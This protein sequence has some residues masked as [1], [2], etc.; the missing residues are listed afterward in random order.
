MSL[1]K[2]TRRG[3]L[4]ILASTVVLVV[5]VI[6]SWT[7]ARGQDGNVVMETNSETHGV[8][9]GTIVLI[10]G[11]CQPGVVG[12]TSRTKCMSRSVSRKVYLYSP[13]VL[14]RQFTDTYYG[15]YRSPTL[16]G[17]SDGDGHYEIQIRPGPYSILVEDEMRQYC[18]RFSDRQACAVTIRPG[19]R[20]RYDLKIEHITF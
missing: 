8:I 11:N 13:P 4:G 5:A 19:Q 14:R 15:G 20:A 12:D 16:I 10:D 2:I 18:N 1:S 7:L 9:Y 6:G 17:Q 3:W